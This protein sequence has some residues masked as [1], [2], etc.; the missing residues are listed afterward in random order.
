ML[1]SSC[2]KFTLFVLS[3]CFILLLTQEGRISLAAKPYIK[4]WARHLRSHL[5]RKSFGDR[6]CG[7]SPPKLTL[8]NIT[9]FL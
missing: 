8:V 6:H 5:L 1:S 2:A 3:T 9:S 7:K 4:V